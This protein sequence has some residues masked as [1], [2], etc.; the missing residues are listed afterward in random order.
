M[1][2]PLNERQLQILNVFFKFLITQCKLI[3]IV[4]SQ[5]ALSIIIQIFNAQLWIYPYAFAI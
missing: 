1:I 4:N 3:T 2:N 5:H